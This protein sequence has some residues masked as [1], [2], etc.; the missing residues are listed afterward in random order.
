MKKYRTTK[1]NK[2]PV[3]E[4]EIEKETSVFVW[5]KEQRYKKGSFLTIG[6]WADNPN[7][8]CLQTAGKNNQDYFGKFEVIMSP[9]MAR[10]LGVALINCSFEVERYE[11]GGKL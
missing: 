8:V 4:V 7:F 3:E 2:N 6:P 10:E 11:T 1:W 5:I 9:K